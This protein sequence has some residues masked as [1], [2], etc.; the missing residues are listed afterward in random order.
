MKKAA[1]MGYGELMVAGL[2]S[3][4]TQWWRREGGRERTF[5]SFLFIN[6]HADFP[7]LFLPF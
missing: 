4:K 6:F 5:I 3:E 2:G 1:V 7:L